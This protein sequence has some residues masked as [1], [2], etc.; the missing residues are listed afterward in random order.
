[1]R[2]LVQILAM[3]AGV[4][5]LVF[6][7]TP[8]FTILLSVLVM[9][10]GDKT[11]YATAASPDGEREA[12]VQ[13]I[14]CGATCSF[15]RNVIVKSRTFPFGECGVLDLDGDPK[16]GLRWTGERVLEVSYSVPREDIEVARDHC[17]DVQ[18]RLGWTPPGRSGRP[19][20]ARPG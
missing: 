15:H 14:D 16:V 2:N 4:G 20:R 10:A 3:L 1:M 7:A 19:W 18:V 12:L 13:F 17:H 5:L 8:A 9:P 6:V 11:V